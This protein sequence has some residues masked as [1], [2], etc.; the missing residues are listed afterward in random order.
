MKK[1]YAGASPLI[2]EVLITLITI[3]ITVG[4]IQTFPKVTNII[5]LLPCWE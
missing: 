2:L 1:V 4:P 5:G 3:V